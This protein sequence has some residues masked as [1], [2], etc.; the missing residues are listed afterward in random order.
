MKHPVSRLGASALLALPLCLL[1]SGAPASLAAA[2][3]GAAPAAPQDAQLAWRTEFK[4]AMKVGAQS[5]M[6]RLVKKDTHAAVEWI[7]D[8]AQAISTKTN[9]ELETRMAALRKAWKGAIGSQ[10]ADN[11][12]EYFSLLEQVYKD[13]RNR[14]K[15]RYDKAYNRYFGNLEKKDQPTFGV[16]YLEFKMLAEAYAE[17]GDFYYASQSWLLCY[18]CINEDARGEQ[19]DLYKACAALKMVVEERKKIDLQ[20]RK[21]LEAKSAYTYLKAQGYDGEPG[22]G[23]EGEGGEPGTGGPPKAGPRKE[24]AAVVV[25]MGFEMVEDYD[26]FKR[27]SYY[28]DEIHNL[29]T[30][31]ALQKK[32]SKATFSSLGQMSPKVH[33]AG[34]SEVLI[35]ADGDGEG[36]LDVP[37]RGNVDPIEFEITDDSGSRP[38]GCLTKLGTQSDMYQNIQ[39]SMQPSDD[40]LQLYLAA[41]ASMVGE[42]AGEQVRIIDENMD[43]IYGGPPTFWGHDGLT[44]DMLHPEFDSILIGAKAKR[45]VPFSEYQKIGDVWYRLEVEGGGTSIRAYPTELETGKVK[46]SFKGG[47]PTFLVVQGKGKYENS[48][49]DLMAKG[50]ELPVGSYTLLCGELRKGKKLQTVKALMLPGKNMPSWTVSAGETTA[51]KL[52]APFGFDFKF[53][54][55]SKSVTVLGESIA[56]T[57]S[58]GERYERMWNCVPKPEAAVRPKGKGRG[59]KPDDMKLALSQ[60]EINQGG[61]KIA[62][63]PYDLTLDKKGRFDEA[64]VQLAEKKN[65]LFGKINS[66]WKE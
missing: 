8:T 10:F 15:R 6:E 39:V 61:W 2:P 49:F 56:I 18:T 53:E 16:L 19:A 34:S 59:G 52:G 60:D 14:L 46:V 28:A 37:L 30:R 20:D 63:F 13:E 43:G 5:E 47:K 4:K 40:Q 32:G 29:W 25:E 36:E 62:W 3:A 50:V 64:E 1:A 57:G 11:M 21:Y 17:L 66:D 51:V 26:K 9:D 54:N 27:P 55:G 58:G 23:E 44:K 12:Y 65:K 42:V 41:G 7:I 22:A 45:A 35:D 38:W 31:I 24:G 33:R 48:Y